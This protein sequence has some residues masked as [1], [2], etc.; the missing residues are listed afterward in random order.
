MRL[1]GTM[2]QKTRQLELPYRSRGEAPRVERSGEAP[3]ASNGDE[4]SGPVTE[5][6]MEQVVERSNMEAALKR[7]KRNKGSPGTDGMTVQELSAYVAEHGENL[8]VSL[9][10]G[11][12]SP[13]PVRRHEIPKSGEGSGS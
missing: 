2:R 5:F 1:D 13:K 8:R 6:L 11:T 10:A 3:T 7:V 9:L 4:R 12:Y